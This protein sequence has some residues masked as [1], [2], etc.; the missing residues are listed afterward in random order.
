MSCEYKLTC[1]GLKTYF[2]LGL[3]LEFYIMS[4][5]AVDC[6]LQLKKRV[7]CKAASC[8]PETCDTTGSGDFPWV[9]LGMKGLT[10][11]L[12]TVI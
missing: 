10:G 4:I 3:N 7:C 5:L 11:L 12:V 6:V 8:P 9:L 2:T 1:E